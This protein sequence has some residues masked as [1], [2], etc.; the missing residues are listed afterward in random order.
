MIQELLWLEF[1][2]AAAVL[3]FSV[4]S[5]HSLAALLTCALHRHTALLWDVSFP[6]AAS[7]GDGA[8]SAAA[9]LGLARPILSPALGTGERIGTCRTAEGHFSLQFISSST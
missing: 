8:V 2:F 6:V 9:E 7:P 4:L 3:I 5:R 1:R